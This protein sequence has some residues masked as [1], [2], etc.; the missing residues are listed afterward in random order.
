ML[1]LILPVVFHGNAC[2]EALASGGPLIYAT[3]RTV[4]TPGDVV[5]I[6]VANT[7]DAPVAIV[8]RIHIDGGFATIE[9]QVE[10]GQWRVI[11]LYA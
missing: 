2:A 10:N 5:K 4:Y 9:K 6:S 11:E 7:S 1:G 3:D 8:D